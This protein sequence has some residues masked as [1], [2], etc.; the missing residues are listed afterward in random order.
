MSTKV[1]ETDPKC[2]THLLYALE[3]WC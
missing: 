2:V 1:I 3:S